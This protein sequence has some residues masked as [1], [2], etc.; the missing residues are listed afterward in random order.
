MAEKRKRGRPR[1]TLE[2]VL[3]EIGG[4]LPLNWQEQML[5]LFRVGYHEIEVQVKLGINWRQ[6][7]KFKEENEEF[8][9]TLKE[10]DKLA[11]AFYWDIARTNLK[12]SEFRMPLFQF[13]MFNRWGYQHAG[14]RLEHTGRIDHEV[15]HKVKEYSN[16]TPEELI[17]QI[18]QAIE[19]TR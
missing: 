16:L 17:G 18:N 14:V 9:I 10:G 19:D 8:R 4:D 6:W 1:K 3:E 13:I 7:S 12:N 5:D 15:H 2:Q 11:Q